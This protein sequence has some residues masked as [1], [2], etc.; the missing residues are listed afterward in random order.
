MY[1]LS[2]THKIKAIWVR[3]NENL[4][5]IWQHRLWLLVERSKGL[6]FLFLRNRK[7]LNFKWGKKKKLYVSAVLVQFECFV[8]FILKVCNL[9]VSGC[10]FNFFFLILLPLPHPHLTPHTLPLG[11]IW[12]I[13]TWFVVERLLSKAVPWWSFAEY[14]IQNTLFLFFSFFS[15]AFNTQP[16]C[17]SPSFSWRGQ[18]RHSMCVLGGAIRQ[19][20]ALECQCLQLLRIKQRFLYALGIYLGVLRVCGHCSGP[21]WSSCCPKRPSPI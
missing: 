13:G 4:K 12:L 18:R 5:T 7:L 20:V 3:S 1:G 9:T 16:A 11:C 15:P 14:T 8:V 17:V 21:R 19:R 2:F 10:I 6:V